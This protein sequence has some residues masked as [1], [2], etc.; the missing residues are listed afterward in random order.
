MEV[1]GACPFNSFW[2]AVGKQVRGLDVSLAL[3]YSVDY[4]LYTKPPPYRHKKVPQASAK[5]R[6]HAVGV[7]AQSP[8][9]DRSVE[10]FL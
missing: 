1:L 5:I 2:G 6:V 10:Q 9:G 8:G 4:R 7:S 3:W